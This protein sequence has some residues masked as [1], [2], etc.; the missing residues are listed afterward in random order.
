MGLDVNNCCCQGYDGAAN[1][2]SEAV[3]IQR[4]IKKISSEKVF[5]LIVVAIT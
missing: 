5:I 4:I 1:M 3:G 2:I